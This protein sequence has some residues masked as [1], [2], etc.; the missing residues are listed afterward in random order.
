MVANVLA[1]VFAYALGTFPT[2]VLVAKREGHDVLDEGSHNPGASNVYRVAGWK[3]GAVVL[4][5]DAIKGGIAAGLGRYLGGPAMGLVVGIAAVVGHCFPVQRW[6]RGGK[7]VA[8]AGG[9]GIVV[10]PPLAIVLTVIWFLIARVLNKASLGSLA[11]LVAAPLVV[12]G[13][14][15]PAREVWLLAALCVLVLARHH[16]NIRRLMRG[17]EASLRSPA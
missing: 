1:V 5:G 16:G 11:V 17:E 14:G 3:A 9:V 8:T 6:G 15:R 13:L 10:Y 7:G 12:W 2:G 4:I